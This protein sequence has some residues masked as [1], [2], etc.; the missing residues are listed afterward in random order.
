MAKSINELAA[1]YDEARKA[2]DEAKRAKTEAEAELDAISKELAEAMIEAE[3][4]SF[5]TDNGMSYSLTVKD[6]YSSNADKREELFMALRENGLGDIIN[7]TVNANTLSAVMRE[8][9]EETGELP[10]AYRDCVSCYS[11]TTISRRK[12]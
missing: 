11:K 3:I 2:R 6:Y 1:R 5:K 9:A 10:E 12:G 7:E 4:T 8:L